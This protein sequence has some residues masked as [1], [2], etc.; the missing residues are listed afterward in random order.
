MRV[1]FIGV[2]TPSTPRFL[3]ARHSAPFE[4]GDISEAVNRWV[5]ELRRR[6]VEAIVVLAHAGAPAQDESDA[7]DFAGEIVDEARRDEL[8]RWTW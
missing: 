4:F 5:P 1:G 6:G 8:A 2:T 3:L 7:P